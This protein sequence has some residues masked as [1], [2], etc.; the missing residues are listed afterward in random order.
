VASSSVS[1]QKSSLLQ[2]SSA[3]H[4][5]LDPQTTPFL[6]IQGSKANV[7]TENIRTQGSITSE[8]VE[9]LLEMTFSNSKPHETTEKP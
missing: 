3:A 7:S 8:V 6:F 4:V 5:P 9:V 2:V 1:K